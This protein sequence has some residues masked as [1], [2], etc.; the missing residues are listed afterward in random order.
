MKVLYYPAI[1]LTALLAPSL[2][3]AGTLTYLDFSSTSGITLLPSATVAGNQ[4]QLTSNGQGQF[5]Q[6]WFNTLQ[7]VIGGFIANFSYQLTGGSA[8]GLG[9]GFA[10]VIQNDPNGTNARGTNAGGGSIGYSYYNLWGEG[11]VNGLAIEFN[12][13]T[14]HVYIQ[15][16]GSGPLYSN[17]FGS[18]CTITSAGTGL[19]NDGNPHTVQ[20]DYNG[21]LLTVAFDGGAPALSAPINLGSSLNLSG[22]TSAFVGFTAGSGGASEFA[23]IQSFDFESTPEPSTFLLL[24]SALLAGLA[25]R[26]RL[27]ATRTGSPRA[28]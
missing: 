28:D 23:N 19:L 9:D 15:N 10:F 8:F 1:A 2:A 20:V 5:G 24:G 13:Y 4:L 26:G 21:A 14:S 16:C 7:E 27:T 3:P 6:A 22:G 11:M 12:A 18:G 17:Q 25:L